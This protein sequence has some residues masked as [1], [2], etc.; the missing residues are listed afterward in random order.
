[1]DALQLMDRIAQ[2]I[3]TNK[4][5]SHSKVITVIRDG[6]DPEYHVSS[7]NLVHVDPETFSLTADGPL[8][9]VFVNYGHGDQTEQTSYDTT[10]RKQVAKTYRN[11]LN[12][13]E[14]I[15][16]TMVNLLNIK[17]EV[18]AEFKS[19]LIR[20]RFGNRDPYEIANHLTE[21]GIYNGNG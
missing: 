21:M 12:S 4:I 15:A 16:D 17:E 7:E 19:T 18:A 6:N 3:R 13:A 1:M 11:I 8:K 2:L 10:S 14:T 5:D 20:D 9:L